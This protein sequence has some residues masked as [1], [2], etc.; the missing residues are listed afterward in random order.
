MVTTQD[1]TR[2]P[3]NYGGY[4]MPGAT[5]DNMGIL[6]SQWNTTPDNNGIPYT[7]EQFQVNPHN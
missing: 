1:P 7:V 6:V 2:V 5:L 4:I 3:Q